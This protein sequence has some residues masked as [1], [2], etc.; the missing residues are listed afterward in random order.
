MS[1]A[2]WKQYDQCFHDAVPV[3]F[4]PCRLRLG[5]FNVNGKL[6][7]QD[8]SP[9]VRGRVD[10]KPP[11]PPPKNSLPSSNLEGEKSSKESADG[12]HERGSSQQ[13]LIAP[14][15]PLRRFREQH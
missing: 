13:V 6:P 7:S 14:Y 8:L 5:T 1:A 15:A 9:W 12:T 10:Q 11:T 4:E 3:I 2:Q